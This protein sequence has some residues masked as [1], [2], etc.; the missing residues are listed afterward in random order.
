MGEG[1]ALG[2]FLKVPDK[3][4]RRQGNNLEREGERENRKERKE[5]E[6]GAEF[7]PGAKAQETQT[8]VIW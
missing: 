5:R 3:Q 2:S 4:E 8:G 1:G 7:I 6:G